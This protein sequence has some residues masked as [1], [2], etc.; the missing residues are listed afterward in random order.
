MFHSLKQLGMLT[1]SLLRTHIF[2][3]TISQ[4]HL[5]YG[6]IK[7]GT[8]KTVLVGL[9]NG[10]CNRKLS[11]MWLIFDISCLPYS[12]LYCIVINIQARRKV[13]H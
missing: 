5:Q 13:V 1:V 10:L 9:F 2:G 11:T 4:T 6:N 7:R 12:V 8:F 3:K